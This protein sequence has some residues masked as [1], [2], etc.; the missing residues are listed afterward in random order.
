M[1]TKALNIEDIDEIDLTIE[2]DHKEVKNGKSRDGL[3][4]G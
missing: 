1:Y 3:L 4:G 2:K